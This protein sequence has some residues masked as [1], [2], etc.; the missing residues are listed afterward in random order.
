MQT[1]LRLLWN[2]VLRMNTDSAVECLIVSAKGNYR[3]LL[4][5][6]TKCL[7]L[8]PIKLP[9]DALDAKIIAQSYWLGHEASESDLERARINCWEY[10]DQNSADNDEVK[11]SISATRAVICTLYGKPP[12]DDLSELADF[13][14]QMLF[15]A[16][17]KDDIG[18]NEKLLLAVNSFRQ[19]NEP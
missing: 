18:F 16:N 12:S 11:Q 6:M 1:I 9:E 15:A 19:R 4:Q 5:L 13:F 14:V 17:A 7:D 10:L 8:I 3:S 2:T